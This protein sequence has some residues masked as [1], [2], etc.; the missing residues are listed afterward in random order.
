MT[1]MSVCW[2]LR[3]SPAHHCGVMHVLGTY[4]LLRKTVTTAVSVSSQKFCCL[5]LKP[6]CAL[7]HTCL[8]TPKRTPATR[9]LPVRLASVPL[10][11]HPRLPPE[12]S[13]CSAIYY[14]GYGPGGH[15][16]CK[17]A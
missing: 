13:C 14:T 8:Q 16:P 11:R 10:F 5:R 15:P 4:S 3:V 6:S 12:H 2:G 1:F 17:C 9:S 7:L